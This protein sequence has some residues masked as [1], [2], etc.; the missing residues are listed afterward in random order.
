MT[1]SIESKNFLRSLQLLNLLI[2]IG[3]QNLILCPGSRSAPLAIAA[4]ELNKLGLVNIFNSIDERSAG[5]HSLGISAASGNLSL[6]ITTSGTAVSN[7]LPAA[8]EADR[9]CKGIIFLTADRPLRLK[10][11]GANQTVN[12]EDF[13]SSVCR[14]VLNTNL[15]GLHETEDNEILNLVQIIE[16]EISTFPGPIHLN[17]PIDKPLDITFVNKK[18]VLAVFERIYLKKKYV[19]QKNEIMSNKNKLFE[20]SK[21]L[22]LD[23]SGIILVGPYQGSI[24]ELSSFNKSLEQLQEI[25]GWPVF[26]DPVS[27]VYSDLRGLVVNWELVLRKNKNFINCQQILRLGPMSSSIDLEKF[28]TRFEG[29]Q[30]LIKEKNLRKLDPIKKSFEYEFGLTKFVNQLLAD[31]SINQKNKKSLNSLALD[32]IEEG[33]KIKKILKE[34]ITKNNQ[35]TEYKLANLVPKIWPAENPIM[36][37]A[38][39]PIRDW[40]TFSENCTLTRNCFSFRGASGI[41]GTLSLAL[42]ISRIKNPLLLV[43]GDLAFVHDINGWLIENSIDLNLT[44]LLIN[45]NGGNIF[46]RLYKKNLK[47][48]E[49]K[50]LFLMPKK[51]NWEKLAGAYQ[52]NFKSVTNFKKL[53]ESLEWSICI[54]KSVIIKVDIDPENEINEKNALLEKIIGS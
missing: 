18:S 30:I 17:I 25:T 13:L 22:N 33:E 35:I 54:Q 43:T 27:G 36:L 52:V 28:L 46:N 31:L 45:N 1:S 53:R 8:V 4:G 20:I 12:Q 50:K 47:E 44:I 49:L 48:D 37:S 29:N 14:R 38:S 24:N 11:C 40:L 51:I 9:S 42:G 34:K 7:L 2:K 21:S 10:D 3:V 41:D 6:V 26:A 15:N 19:F 32:L 5:F 16:E 23:E 39:S